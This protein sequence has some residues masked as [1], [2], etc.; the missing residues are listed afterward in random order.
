MPPVMNPWGTAMDFNPMPNTMD[1]A[2]IRKQVPQHGG[3]NTGG[4]AQLFH[5][6]I[7]LV[8]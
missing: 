1:P 8:P 4:R 3:D 7:P 5:G 6:Q 2:E